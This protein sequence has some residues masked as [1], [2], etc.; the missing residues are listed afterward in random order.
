[1][2]TTLAKTLNTVAP[3]YVD[4][5]LMRE[6]PE[7]ILNKIVDK[8]PIHRLGTE[9]EVG[10]AVVFLVD[11]KSAWTTGSTLTM[12]GGTQMY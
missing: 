11:E 10:H 9:Q 1:M 4:T 6:M 8:S 5:Y 3:G 12:N 7:R 2:S